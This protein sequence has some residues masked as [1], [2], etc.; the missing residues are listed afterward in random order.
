MCYRLQACLTRDF[1]LDGRTL[2]SASVLPEKVSRC[3]TFRSPGSG[4]RVLAS[5]KGIGSWGCLCITPHGASFCSWTSI[6]LNPSLLWPGCILR[7]P[8]P[9]LCGITRAYCTG[10]KCPYT[11]SGEFA[12]TYVSNSENTR[13]YKSNCL[14]N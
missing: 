6:S 7:L 8:F 11:F 10:G 12:V 4:T 13:K 2:I 5:I 14:K 1:S 3:F 9:S